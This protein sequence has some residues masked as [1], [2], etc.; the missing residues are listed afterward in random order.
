MTKRA[1]E[2]AAL[3]R[4]VRELLGRVGVARQGMVV[5]VSGGADSVALLRA[6][7]VASS[8][9][10]IAHLN[11]QLRGAESDA[12]E[13][14]VRAL[15]AQL[16]AGGQEGLQLRCERLDVAAHA[17][18]DGDNLEAVAR[19]LRYAWLAE[20]ARDAGLRLVATGHTADDQ[21]ETVLHRLLRGTGLRGLRGIATRRSLTAEIDVVRPLLTT[22]R[23]EVLA[24]LAGLGQDYRH[25]SSND[26]RQLTRNRIRHELLP[27]LA[28]EYNPEIAA[29]L[30]R[31][32]EEADA[33]YRVED[34]QAA[35]LLAEA[36]R[37]RAGGLLIFDRARLAAAPRHQVRALFRHVW[38]REGWPTAAMGFDAWDRLAGVAL[39]EM[40]AVDLP[41]GV[42]TRLGERVVQVG[43][44]P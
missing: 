21:A 44:R 38:E 5:A 29:V 23:A 16:V 32:A 1:Y 28:R 3:P 20:V 15:H 22:T 41:G 12:D 17:R 35:A 2:S 26:S 19:R 13:D 24:Y 9:L 39:G 14:F 18:A 10:V 25:D 6:L 31:L 30:G 42:S 43:P 8:Q 40:T 34:A 4:R 7:L 37:P 33:A 36:E 27:L 11:H